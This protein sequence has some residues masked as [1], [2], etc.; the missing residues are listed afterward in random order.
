MYSVTESNSAG[1]SNVGGSVAAGGGSFS[2]IGLAKAGT[3]NS[4]VGQAFAG[5]YGTLLLNANGTFT[6]SLNNTDTDTNALGTGM[7]GTERFTYTYSL[8]G[9]VQTA[10]L[11][12]E[13]NGVDEVGQTVETNSQAWIANPNDSVDALH[14][15]HGLDQYTV[16]IDADW[17]ETGTFVNNGAI[18][19][20]S[21]APETIAIGIWDSEGGRLDIVNNGLI[22]VI[23]HNLN[24]GG[25]YGAGMGSIFNSG[26]VRVT[27]DRAPNPN[28]GTPPGSAVGV[29]GGD[30][31]NSGTIEVSAVHGD[32]FGVQSGRVSNSGLIYVSGRGVIGD[33]GLTVGISAGNT[34]ALIE[35]SGTIQVISTN[36]NQGIGISLFPNNTNPYQYG[37]VINSGVIVADIAVQAVQG[38]SGGTHI[39]NSGRIEGALSFDHNLNYV[40][41]GATGIW[42]GDL[43]FGIELDVLVNAGTITGNVYLGAGEDLFDGRGGGSVSGTVDAGDYN[44][45][46]RGGSNADRLHGGPGSDRIYGG[47]GADT[48]SGGIDGDVFLYSA[49][50]DSTTAV[51]DTITDFQT[52]VDKID[53]T[54]L[55]PSSVSISVSGGYTIVTAVVVGG[56]LSIRV[57]GSVVASDIVTNSALGNQLGTSGQDILEAVTGNAELYGGDGNDALHGNAGDNY[58]DGGYGSD[59][60]Y[61][62]DGNDRYLIVDGGDRIFEFEDGGID[63]VQTWVDYSLPFNVENL[64]LLGSGDTGALGNSLN[65]LLTGNAGR[66]VLRGA[67]GQD[68]IIGGLGADALEGGLGAPDR[69]VYLSADDSI[70]SSADHIVVFEHGI[71]VIDLTAVAPLAFTFIEQPSHIFGSWPWASVF[72]HFTEVRVTTASGTTMTI[73]VHGQA[74]LADF[75][76]NA[77]LSGTAINDTLIGSSADDEI[78]GGAGN[79]T[80]IGLAGNDRLDGGEGNDIL[81]GGEGEDEILY[82]SAPSAVNVNLALDGAQNTGGAGVDTLVSIE[83]VR[84]SNYGDVLRGDAGA[85]VLVGE[86]GDDRLFGGAGNDI[87]TGGEGYDR[88][89]GGAGDDFYYVVDATDFTYENAGEGTD[90]VSSSVDHQ[91]RENVEHLVIVGSALI[92]KGNVLGNSIQGN[93]QNNRLYGYDGNDNIGGNAGDDYLFGGAGNDV[94]S[95]WTGYDR[96]YGGT[97][98]D[99]YIVSDT[100]DYAYENVGEGTDKV[101][102]GINHTLRDNIE[103]LELSGPEDLRGYGNALDNRIDGGGG[104]NLLYGRDGADWL[105]G[106]DGNDIVYGENGDDRLEGGAGQDRFYGG[107]GFDQFIFRD[108]DFAGMTSST[109]DRIHDYLAG[110]S[111]LISMVNVDANVNV[112]GDQNFTFINGAAF[113]GTAGELRYQQISGNTYVMGDVNGDGAADFWIRIDGQH[114]LQSSYFIL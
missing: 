70:A 6:Y 46:M 14:Q 90:Y 113:S 80:L 35:N 105:R 111:D 86:G 4:G 107:S 44:D 16:L 53:L 19:S 25:I 59:T 42:V 61:G 10:T 88:M 104:N 81:D 56:M 58:F 76:V 93:D 97:G 67:E 34:G 32:A 91:L 83:R 63:E 37:T 8:N 84:G 74:T 21:N 68:V 52:G 78:D 110:G 38:Y 1:T 2:V 85:N 72:S 22:D 45:M 69:F 79:D 112:D 57:Q 101:L 40:E 18:V 100:T 54:Q 17:G 108:G 65:N 94:L 47:G 98:D 9:V 82:L 114:V 27:A 31:V 13:I 96:M 48:L 11:S 33:P 28:Q 99:I 20:N 64:T 55:A 51:R 92:G 71:D 23:S 103:N 29:G 50:S 109:A 106:N 62:G 41:N 7:I 95:G 36:G 26:V 87:V 39:F 77:P 12:F 49:L 30:I 75:N 66:N 15:L 89:Y 43:Q 73:W 5:T 3:S 60:L 102:A 24:A